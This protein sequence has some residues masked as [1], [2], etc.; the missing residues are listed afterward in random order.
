MT[1]RLFPLLR[2]LLF[3]LLLNSCSTAMSSKAITAQTLAR[4][5][6]IAAEPR[7]DFWIGRRFYIE[8]T[9]MWGYV[10]RPGQ[11]WD[12]SRLVVIGEHR[13]RQPDRFPE[14]ERAE[15]RYGF[16]HNFEYRLF[17][18]FT[19][20][21]VYDP[22]SNLVL[23]E[24]GTQR[25]ELLNTQAGWLFKPGERFTGNQLLRREEGADP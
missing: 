22:N 23:P 14:D 9:H 18:D 4:E 10:R 19:G 20:R 21:H 25:Y 24:F 5:A 15:R 7:G 1:H 13:G 11:S 3:V 2:A 16:D 12:S 17:G 6:Q 8:R